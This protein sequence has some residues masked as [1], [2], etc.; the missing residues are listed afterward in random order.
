L[1]N[2][3]GQNIF[4][5]ILNNNKYLFDMTE[6]NAGIYLIKIKSMAGKVSTFKVLKN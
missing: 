2:I 4:N 5:T 3:L 1:Y 6:F